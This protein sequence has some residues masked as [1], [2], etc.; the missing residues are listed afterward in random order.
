[1]INFCKSIVQHINKPLYDN[2]DVIL[3]NGS[4]DSMFKIFET[5]CDESTTVLM[6]EFTF[7]PVVSNV[8]ATGATCVPL[9]MQLT[10]DRSQQGLDIEY[11][12]NLLKNWSSIPQYK[13]LNKPRILYTISTGQN[14][15]GMTLSMEKRRKIYQLAQ[16]HDLIIVEDD[17]YGYLLFPPYDPANP[18]KN[19]Y[20]DSDNPLTVK[21]Y[22]ENHLVKSFLTMDTDARVIRLETFSKLFAPG[23]R[24]GFIV[25]NKFII[26]RIL[27]Y[28]EITTRAAS[29]SSQAIVY[30]TVKAMAKKQTDIK[31]EQEAMFQG[32]IQW[33]MKLAGKYTHRRNITVK[34]LYETEAYKKGLFSIIEPSAGMFINIAF[35]WP[36]ETSKDLDERKDLMDQLDKTLV[37]NGV[38][39]VL[40]Y[41]MAVDQQFSVDSFGFLRITVAFAKDDAQLIEASRRIGKGIEEFF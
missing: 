36:D 22:T 29:G 35:N 38:K 33:A 5:L 9:Q 4:S 25:A 11:M 17:P 1:M 7:S 21:T 19:P 34:A 13:H 6:E 27:N 16:E 37:K 40:G 30:A 20:L 28:T 2:W 26:N 14:P 12:T 32:W 3:A 23:L 18:L 39:V 24:L 15:T 10:T 31:N 8:I 41:K